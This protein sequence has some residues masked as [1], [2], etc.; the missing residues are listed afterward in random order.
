MFVA[1]RAKSIQSGPLPDTL[2]YYAV[3]PCGGSFMDKDPIDANLFADALAGESVTSSELLEM[4]TS[5]CSLAEA[6]S[7]AQERMR[8]RTAADAIEGRPPDLWPV[9]EVRWDFN[10]LNF[11]R[12]FD[13][14]EPTSSA[15][16]ELVLI[17][18]VSLASINSALT[19]YWHR[20]ADEVWTVGSPDKTARAIVYWCEGG[21][22]TPPLLIPTSDGKLAIAGGNHRL[23]VARAK[24]TACLPILSR[25]AEEKRVR[26]ILA[27]AEGD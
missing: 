26:Q 17:P 25:S 8:V 15:D 27:V 18:D 13:G 7:R 12:V 21:L 14:A 3:R 1:A 22:M 19:P 5:G 11:Y 9:F 16:N 6:Q 10:P 20:T 2:Q 23:A 24:L 4:A